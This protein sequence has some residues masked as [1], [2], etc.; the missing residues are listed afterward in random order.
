MRPETITETGVTHA[1]TAWIAY[2]TPIAL[3]MVALLALTLILRTRLSKALTVTMARLMMPKPGFPVEA[4]LLWAPPVATEGQLLAI[5]M[6]SAFAVIVALLKLMPMFVALLAAAP[7]TLAFMYLT[8]RLLEQRYRTRLDKELV[9]AVGRLGA[10]LRSGQGITG[11][12]NKVVTDLPDGPLKAEWAFMLDRMGV[13]LTGGALATPPQVVAALAAQTLSPRHSGFLQHLEVALTQT[14]D[15]LN[16][17]VDAAYTALQYSERRASEANTE[18]A[19]MRYSGM[20]VGGAGLFMAVY[21]GLSQWERVKVAYSGPLGMIVGF[22]VALALSG[23]FVAGIF[24]SRSDD[25][26]Y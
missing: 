7:L 16:R 15:V 22:I 14:H 17:R 13:P 19:Q 3:T 24:L 4:A 11:A 10:Q 21:L 12:L 20:A 2:A 23:P 6:S 8:Y 26:D 9:A 5:S 1:T 18:L 25:M